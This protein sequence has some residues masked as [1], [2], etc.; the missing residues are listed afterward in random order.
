MNPQHRRKIERL[1]LGEQALPDHSDN[2]R[3]S[4][5]LRKFGHMGIADFA[6]RHAVVDQLAHS[7]DTVGNDFVVV[8]VRKHREA[9]AF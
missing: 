8:E 9:P 7:D 5:Q 3:R 6:A 2:E 4:D 1:V